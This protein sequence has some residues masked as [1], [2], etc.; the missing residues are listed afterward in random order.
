LPTS[1]SLISKP[2][3][4]KRRRSR[5]Y[6]GRALSIAKKAIRQF[7]D[8]LAN[9]ILVE[10]V[11]P[12]LASA[13]LLKRDTLRRLREKFFLLFHHFGIDSKDP[14]GWVKLSMC[15]ATNFVPGLVTIVGDPLVPRNSRSD[16]FWTLAR[17]K[18]LVSGVAARLT[19]GD[20]KPV[21][22]ESAVFQLVE[23]EPKAW[24]AF[25]GKKHTLVP[26][27]YEGKR[28]IEEDAIRESLRGLPLG[29]KEWLDLT[30]DLDLTGQG[31]RIKQ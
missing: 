14:G 10:P 4:S 12:G 6:N 25:K 22:I 23:E 3:P 5:D 28:L 2:R 30:S 7:S 29:A 8:E 24:G 26:R 9:P 13:T 20:G 21:K 18:T 19:N 15:L 27:F 17:Y 16:K 1:K 31:T 11:G